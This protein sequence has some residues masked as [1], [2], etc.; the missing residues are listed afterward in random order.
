M[1]SSRSTLPAH[2]FRSHAEYLPFIGG[3]AMSKKVQYRLQLNALTTPRSYRAQPVPKE[4]SGY[5]EMAALIAAKNPVWSPG[6]V[7]SILLMEREVI[8]EQL[9][10][11][12]QVSYENAFTYHLSINAR[13]DTLDSPLPSDKNIVNVQIYASRT[14][15]DEVRQEVELE[16]LPPTQ[17]LP[18]IAA[19]EDKVLKLNDVL[20]PLGVLRL[21]GTDL[22]FQPGETGAECVIEGTRSGRTVQS[23]FGQ[24]SNT[25]L[26]VVPEIP[27][28]TDPWNNEY[29]LSVSTRYTENGSLRTGTYLRPLRT[30]LTVAGFGHPHLQV[31]ILTDNAA[32]PHVVVTGGSL[33][34]NSAQVRIQAVLNAQDGQLRLNLIDMKED[35]SAGNT[36]TVAGNGTFTLQ[37][38]AGSA[39]TALEV[40]VSNYTNLLTM[41]RNEYG[42]RVVDILD[43]RTGS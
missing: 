5:D 7:K 38:F 24:I 8:K 40:T 3:T 25:E 28:Q 32:A 21:T 42:G 43:V 2:R 14:F 39:L 34:G 23:R 12:N 35:G 27:A 17:K 19:A 22:F 41:V 10:S 11:G 26:I 31:G 15:V 1:I 33:T 30:P 16:R 18:V 13:L 4:S 20:N 29:R 36:V 9:V 6:L 37:G